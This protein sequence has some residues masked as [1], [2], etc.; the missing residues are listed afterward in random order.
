MILIFRET[1]GIT[2][3]RLTF[4]HGAIPD[5]SYLKRSGRTIV[6]DSGISGAVQHNLTTGKQGGQA[7]EYYHLTAAEYGGNWGAK[8]LTTTGHVVCDHIH[9][10]GDNFQI[11]FG[12]GDDA[13]IYY[14]DTNMLIV[15]DLAGTGNVVIG[16]GTAGKDYSLTFDGETNDG[17]LTWMEDEDYFLFG[18]TVRVGDATN[19]TE[20]A[21]DLSFAGTSRIDWSKYTADSI[22]VSSGT[23]T[24]AVA[25]LQTA[26]DG[27]QVAIQEAAGGPP[28]LTMIVD[29]VS[30]TAFNWVHIIDYYEGSTTHSVAIELYNWSTTNWDCFN[31]SNGV[32]NSMTDHSFFVPSDTNY[33]GTGGDAGKVRVRFDHVQSGNASHNLYVDVVALYQ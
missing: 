15:P 18:D 32:E 30:V 3:D 11:T 16:K 8:D 27:N 2:G 29:F 19:Y 14:D 25:D 13:G 24:G 5:G 33:I 17:V 20:V 21:P 6:G 12:A 31:S 26:F 10:R 23:L 9:A 7:N 4:G 22:T 1:D 28:C